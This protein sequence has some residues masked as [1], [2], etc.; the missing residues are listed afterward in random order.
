[1]SK[2][3]IETATRAEETVIA[4]LEDHGKKASKQKKGIGD[5]RCGD[6][7]IEVKARLGTWE[8]EKPPYITLGSK[9]L[10]EFFEKD[11]DDFEVYFVRSL[12]QQI[13]RV[14]GTVLNKWLKEHKKKKKYFLQI[15]LGKEFWQNTEHFEVL[16]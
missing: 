15:T 11:P 16:K 3:N 4:Y 7:V 8:K 10:T 5:L 12:G 9:E 13:V 6:T 14:K 2:K 1:M